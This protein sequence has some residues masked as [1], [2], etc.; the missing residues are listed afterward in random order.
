MKSVTSCFT[1]K[2]KDDAIGT[3]K[4]KPSICKVYNLKLL[5]YLK[6]YQEQ[7]GGKTER[8]Q[9]IEFL[10]PSAKEIFFT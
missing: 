2:Q 3:Q 4:T 8:D 9:D 7:T 1:T 6:V 10:Q 5:K